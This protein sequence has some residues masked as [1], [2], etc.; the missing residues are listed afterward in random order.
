VFLCFSRGQFDDFVAVMLNA[1][2]LIVD[3]IWLSVP[4]QVIDW[5]SCVWND[6][7]CVDGTCWWMD[8]DYRTSSSYLLIAV[9]LVRHYLL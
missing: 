7:S 8:T 6:L 4:V 1:C 5:K 9:G 3:L 2:F